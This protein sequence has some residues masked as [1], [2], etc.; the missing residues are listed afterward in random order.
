MLNADVLAQA[1]VE[2]AR[3][4]WAPWPFPSDLVDRL[5]RGFASA[6][7]PHIKTAT[8]SSFGSASGEGVQSV[9]S[10]TATVLALTASVVVTFASA[11][12]DTD[13]TL[14]VTPLDSIGRYW[15]VTKSTAGFTLTLSSALGASPVPFD[16]VAFY[17]NGSRGSVACTGTIS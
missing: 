5:A 9:R 12:P 11:Q 3:A 10:G 4:V 16:W 8:V 14:M 15:W 6:I 17:P 7:V 2:R 13:Y 1:M